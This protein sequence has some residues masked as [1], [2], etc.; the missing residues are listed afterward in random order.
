MMIPHPKTMQMVTDQRWHELQV[1]VA[2]E[3]LGMITLLAAGNR[4][5]FHSPKRCR[6]AAS[7]GTAWST[8]L[9]PVSFVLRAI[10]RVSR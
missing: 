1:Q 5:N 10:P 7:Y 8:A 4:E 6:V 9:A 3:R 2:R